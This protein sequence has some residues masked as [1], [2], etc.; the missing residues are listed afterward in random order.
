MLKEVM[1]LS[2]LSFFLLFVFLIQTGNAQPK[3]HYRLKAYTTLTK[4]SWRDSI[5]WFPEFQDGTILLASGFSPDVKVRINYN[6]FWE[7]MEVI[8]EKGDTASLI[9]SPEVKLLNLGNH[10]FYHDDNHGY[11]QILIPGEI[12]LA[13][14][15]HLV[16]MME[17]SNGERFKAADYSRNTTSRF[18]RIYHKEYHYYFMDRNGKLYKVSKKALLRLLP[19]YQRE[20][21][22]YLRNNSIDFKKKRDLLLALNFCNPLVNRQ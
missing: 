12:S 22:I 2:R 16:V 13:I 19:D 10:V 11:V 3:H 20:I 5:Y 4:T 15:C 17:T 8:N 21:K 18:D 14:N 7:Q 6:L 9:S 1:H